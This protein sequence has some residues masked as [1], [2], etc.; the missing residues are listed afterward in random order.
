MLVAITAVLD[1]TGMSIGLWL[2]FYVLAR[3]Y[4]SGLT[5]RAFIILILAAGFFFAAYINVFNQVAGR[6]AWRAVLLIVALY[7]WYDLTRK[8]VPASDRART[9]IPRWSSLILALAASIALLAVPNAFLREAGNALDI[10]QMAVELPFILYGLYMIWISVAMLYNDSLIRQAGLAHKYRFFFTATLIIAI[11]VGHGVLSLAILP[12]QSRIIQDG[13]I[14]AAIIVLGYSIARHQT[15]VERRTTFRDF[16]VSAVAVMGF[17]AIFGLTGLVLD[18]P[19][20]EIGVLVALAVVS[21]GSY[22]FVRVALDGVLH[23]QVSS[24]RG[25]LMAAA[26]SAGNAAQ[27]AEKFVAGLKTLCESIG[28]EGGLIGL[29]EKGGFQV[30]VSVQSLP[31]GDLFGKGLD[32]G[33]ELVAGDP[34]SQGGLHWIAPCTW[35]GELLA[36]V[37]VGPRRAGGAYNEG[38]LDLLSD[39]ADQAALLLHFQGLQAAQR[40]QLSGLAVAFQSDQVLLQTGGEA[41]V[42]KLKQRPEKRLVDLVED[43]LRNLS[44]YSYLGRSPLVEQLNIQGET[45]LIRG[46]GV[47]ER[48]LEL[49]DEL[50]PTGQRPGEPLPREWYSFAVLHDAYV[51]DVPNREIMSRLYISEGTFNRARRNAIRAVARAVQDLQLVDSFG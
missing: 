15:F 9:R 6:A 35:Q 36:L 13:L 22:D 26:G 7:F 25:Q 41:I 21:L 45:H 19:P 12:P 50:R 49:L 34:G 31:K 37:A 42:D 30:A 33:Q 29:P 20:A 10:G 14:L 47:R 3:G 51:E 8:L 38:D 4:R 32:L 43:G 2:A 23:R 27:P 46:R 11:N 16:Q 24:L 17:A 40:D 5:Q 1:L 44:D 18:F 28:A 39:F 48:M